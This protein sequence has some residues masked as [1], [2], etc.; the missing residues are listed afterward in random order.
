MF[1]T[2]QSGETIWLNR[3]T[4]VTLAWE[5]HE[6]GINNTR[7][8][9]QLGRRIRLWQLLGEAQA[10][11]NRGM[12]HPLSFTALIVSSKDCLGVRC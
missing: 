5:L 10:G 2:R 9:Q 11:Y 3:L 12:S 6:Q 1:Q 7:I 4:L 8:A